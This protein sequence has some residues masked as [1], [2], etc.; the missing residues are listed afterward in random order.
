[1]TSIS[2]IHRLVDSMDY[3]RSDKYQQDLWKK[4]THMK[5]SGDRNFQSVYAKM[6][7]QGGEDR[8]RVRSGYYKKKDEEFA[9]IVDLLKM[10]EDYEHQRAH[11]RFLL[12]F[13]DKHEKEPERQHNGSL[14][15]AQV[16]GCCVQ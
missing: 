1:M 6:V 13:L 2:T 16:G 10:L 14:D 4:Y 11:A 15:A 5:E 3:W 12:S 9:K 7:Q 8:Q